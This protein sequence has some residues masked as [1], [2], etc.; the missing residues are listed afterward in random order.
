MLE[1]LLILVDENDNVIGHEEKEKCH[2]GEGKLHR[3]FSIFIFNS[4]GEMLIQRRAP[5]KRLWGGYWTN[6]C[7]SHPRKGEEYAEAANRRLQ[8]ELGFTAG[9]KPLFKFKYTAKFGDAGSENEMDTVFVGTYDGE[10]RV[11]TDEV[12]EWKF[13]DVD[14]L[15]ADI[16][17]NPDRYTPWFKIS[18]ERVLEAQ[19]GIA[20][21]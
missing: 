2:D 8:E 10:V 21:N 13:V 6:S 20:E 18:L 5:G 17:K 1:D 19:G 12:A 15:K 7:C 3:A 14:E 4:K 16:E 9:L 11:N